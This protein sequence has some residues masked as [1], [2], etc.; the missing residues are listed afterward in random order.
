MINA[1]VAREATTTAL[2]GCDARR[3]GALLRQVG[4]FAPVRHEQD[5]VD[6]L[7][8]DGFGAV[9]HGLE[10]RPEAQVSGLA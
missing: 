3:R 2:A 4:L 5:A 8:V 1:V 10:E 9:T 7:E 6:V